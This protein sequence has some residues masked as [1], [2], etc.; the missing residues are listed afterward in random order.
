MFQDVQNPEQGSSGAKTMNDDKEASV[1]RAFYPAHFCS[2]LVSKK[3][4]EAYINHKLV[5]ILVQAFLLA[6]SYILN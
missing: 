3:Y 1:D 4:T 5:D 6:N 2:Y